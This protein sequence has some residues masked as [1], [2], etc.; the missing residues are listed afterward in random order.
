MQSV[1]GMFARW[2]PCF[3]GGCSFQQAVQLFLLPTNVTAARY[4]SATSSAVVWSMGGREAVGTCH[5]GSALPSSL[6]S[7]S[8]TCQILQ[9][10]V[11]VS[12]G[13]PSLPLKLYL[14]ETC[15]TINHTAITSKPNTLQALHKPGPPQK[16]LNYFFVYRRACSGWLGEPKKQ[17]SN[18]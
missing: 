11:C 4:R 13:R 1:C 3:H 17:F 14:V 6:Q 8:Q 15:D 9:V 10:C 12:G 18:S 2:D 5:A 7:L 16:K